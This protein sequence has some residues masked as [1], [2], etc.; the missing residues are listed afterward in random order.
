LAIRQRQKEVHWRTVQ[1]QLS[2]HFPLPGGPLPAEQQQV[3]PE[4]QHAR[5]RHG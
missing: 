3:S 5:L 1:P 4:Q 2:P